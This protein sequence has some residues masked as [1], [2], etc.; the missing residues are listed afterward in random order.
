MGSPMLITSEY[1]T[2]CF[3]HFKPSRRLGIFKVYISTHLPSFRQIAYM[4]NS[5]LFLTDNKKLGL[6]PDVEKTPRSA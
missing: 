4:T 1:V 6:R 5:K 2:R 3:I